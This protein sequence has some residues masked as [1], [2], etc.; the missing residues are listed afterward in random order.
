MLSFLP[1]FFAFLISS[2]ISILLIYYK[3]PIKY[4]QQLVAVL[5]LIMV[6]VL[7]KDIFISTNSFKT[8]VFKWFFLIVSSLLIQI[9]VISSGSIFSPFFILFH[10]AAL[11]LSLLLS[12]STALM[13]VFFSLLVLGINIYLDKYLLGLVTQDIGTVILIFSSFVTIVPITQLL[14][15][16]YHLKDA[17]SKMLAKQITIKE[18][19][20][21]QINELV[22]I[23]DEALNVISANET[24]ERQLHLSNM[25]VKGKPL[26]SLIDLKDENG[27]P[28]TAQ[29]L[30]VANAI[31][32]KS[33]RISEKLLLYLPDKS[34]PLNVGVRVRPVFGIDGKVEQVIFVITSTQ[35]AYTNSHHNNLVQAR[36]RYEAL[37]HEFRKVLA[38]SPQEIRVRA[39]LIHKIEHDLM[40]ATDIEDHPIQLSPIITDIAELCLQVVYEKQYLAKLLNTQLDFNLE[41]P[42]ELSLLDLKKSGSANPSIGASKFSV[43]VDNHWLKVLMQKL[44]DISI[45]L[46]STN[47]YP[48]VILS[49]SEE[50]TQVIILFSISYP[51]IEELQKNELFTEYFGKLGTT[52]NLRL[53]SGLEGF[54]AKNISTHLNIPISV[55]SINHPANLAFKL[56]IKKG[57]NL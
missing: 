42:T 16:T 36:A 32:E 11:G 5:I 48:R 19:I 45:L 7:K 30:S 4:L 9:T 57:V 50:N 34:I 18:S 55:V 28:A 49:T 8:N 35:N 20:I 54:L 21:G 14:S 47:P 6:F 44:L 56:F 10:I 24:I 37:S 27:K 33:T 25:E 12:F 22:F 17:I 53:G 13:F 29:T 23:T 39:A 51:E 52:T 38:N 2:S 26:L 41:D 15:S 31:A 1:S 3:F 40:L 46:S 43:I